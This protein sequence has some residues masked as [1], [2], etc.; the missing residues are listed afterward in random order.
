MH[1]ECL[2]LKAHLGF[3][4]VAYASVVW[5]KSDAFRGGGYT[6]EGQSP[7]GQVSANL[8]PRL[9]LLEVDVP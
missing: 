9:S 8:S 1:S 7:G 6:V 4:T 5:T 3:R 2:V